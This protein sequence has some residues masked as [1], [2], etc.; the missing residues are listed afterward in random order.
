MPSVGASAWITPN[1]PG[2]AAMAESRSTA[3]RVTRG[4]GVDATETIS[5]SGL[6]RPRRERP[7]RRRAAE[8]R[9]E[10][11]TLHCS[12]PPVL[13]TERIA[14]LGCQIGVDSSTRSLFG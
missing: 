8:E 9:D 4:T 11:A 13:P 6:L 14:H 5:P 1:R 12:V 10:L 3:A 7:R 2:P